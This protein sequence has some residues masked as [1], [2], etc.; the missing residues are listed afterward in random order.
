MRNKILFSLSLLLAI[1]GKVFGNLH[2]LTM[3]V[4]DEVSWYLM[5]MGNEIDIHTAHFHGHSFDYK[6]T[7]PFRSLLLRMWGKAN[8]EKR[9]KKMAYSHF[10]QG[11]IKRLGVSMT[12]KQ[13]MGLLSGSA[14][15]F[16]DGFFSSWSKQEF[17]G[18]MSSICSQEHFKQ[19]KWSHRTLERG[20]CTVTLLTTSMQAW[21]QLIQCSQRK[22]RA[23]L[24]Q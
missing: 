17:T 14:T 5:A 8:K 2:G 1:N 16:N 22:V 18:Q 24:P 7:V 12:K 10:R 23:Y 21:K 19:W 13:F 15:L 9:K 6:V 4:G 11:M 3:H 20:Y